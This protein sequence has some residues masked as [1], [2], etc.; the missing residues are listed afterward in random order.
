MAIYSVAKHWRVADH[1]M[2]AS[3]ANS[4]AY[5]RTF[6]PKKSERAAASLL[7]VDALWNLNQ[8][9][10]LVTVKPPMIRLEALWIPQNSM[11]SYLIEP[12]QHSN[13]CPL[14]TPHGT[15]EQ[16]FLIDS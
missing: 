4:L 13:Q 16:V 5:R 3:Q 8:H 9:G 7:G 10:T 12:L 11:L 1:K 14:P 2:A 15:M 6:L